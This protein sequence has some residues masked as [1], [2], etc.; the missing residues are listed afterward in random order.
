MVAERHV[1]GQ[2]QQLSTAEVPVPFAAQI[3]GL[4]SARPAACMHKDSQ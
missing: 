3:L 1:M 2:S 4:R